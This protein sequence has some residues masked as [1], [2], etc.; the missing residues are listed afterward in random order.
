MVR[1]KSTTKIAMASNGKA[2]A[3]SEGGEA[4]RSTDSEERV[5]FLDQAIGEIAQGIRFVEDIHLPKGRSGSLLGTQAVR[6]RRS[7]ETITVEAIDR[8]ERESK[9]RQSQPMPGKK[10]TRKRKRGP[11]VY[12]TRPIE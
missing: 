8:M 2:T 5:D 10:K 7:P 11:K 1:K 12:V 3:P 4:E 9:R 6:P